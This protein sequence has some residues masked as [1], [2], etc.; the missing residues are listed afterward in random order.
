[1]NPESRPVRINAAWH[2]DMLIGK[3]VALVHR[4][5][6]LSGFD[7]NELTAPHYRFAIIFTSRFN[8]FFK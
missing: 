5:F 3:K 6:G 7:Y 1:M 4:K 8:G 2:K